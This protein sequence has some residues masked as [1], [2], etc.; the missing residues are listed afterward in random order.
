M[1]RLIKVL[2]ITA[3]I[4]GFST[5]TSAAW[6]HLGHIQLNY[7]ADTGYSSDTYLQNGTGPDIFYGNPAW[8][9]IAHSPVPLANLKDDVN[10]AYLMLA[11][12]GY[13]FDSNGNW[14]SEMGWGGHIA[15]DWVAHNVFPIPDPDAPEIIGAPHLIGELSYSLYLSLT[16]HPFSTG[17][18]D[19]Q[20]NLKPQRFYPEKIRKGYLNYVLLKQ[21]DDKDFFLSNSEKKLRDFAVSSEEVMTNMTQAQITEKIAGEY[22]MFAG[23]E[24]VAINGLKSGLLSTGKADG[25]MAQMIFIAGAE[26]NIKLAKEQIKLWT[27][28]PS[29]RD[30]SGS[31]DEL[32]NEIRPFPGVLPRRLNLFNQQAKAL[33]TSNTWLG[34]I[35]WAEQ[36]NSSTKQSDYASKIFTEAAER[37]I[38]QGAY[39]ISSTTGADENGE[40]YLQIAPTIIDRPQMEEILRDV[41][42]QESTNTDQGEGELRAA[43][44]LRN[45]FVDEQ[46]DLPK[47]LD[48]TRPTIS[49]L[50]PEDQ[51]T[52][53]TTQP[54]ISA[55]IDDDE[56][57]I[58]ID[59]QLIIMRLD[60]ATVT[61]SYDDTESL[62]TYV[63]PE[64]LASGDHT[65]EL[66]VH[67][68]AGNRAEA[69]SAFTVMTQKPSS[70]SYTG[71][72]S[73]DYSD[74]ANL[75]TVLVDD[76]QIPVPNREVRFALGSQDITVTTDILG[77]A[78]ALLVIDQ[79]WGIKNLTISFG[80][81][82]QYLPSTTQCLFEVAK[83]DTLLGYAGET[84]SKRNNSSVLRAQLSETDTPVGDLN[85]KQ[86][87]FTLTDGIST[88]IA[89]TTTDQNGLAQ[90]TTLITVPAGL[91]NISASFS[92]GDYYLDSLSANTPYVVWEPIDG[93]NISGGGWLIKTGEKTNFGF[94]AKYK[95]NEDWLQGQLQVVDRSTDTSIHA[96]GFD[97]LVVT[98]DDVAMLQGMAT[99]NGVSGHSFRMIVQDQGT[100]GKGKDT[101]ELQ[102]D[103]LTLVS[104]VLDGGNI[105]VH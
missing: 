80:G 57:G 7:E 101:F 72:A 93:T 22:A 3:L 35:A 28:V 78:Q 27:K 55:T 81:D 2:L 84:I 66:E 19:T 105:V 38:A 5:Q 77:R 50:V 96:D 67:D 13:H 29:A 48:S 73:V 58:G 1:K 17:I 15:G 21:Y 18:L 20:G 62:V 8:S 100:P 40:Q 97:W 51:S 98:T 53:K 42:I 56:S 54:M 23:S 104:G 44:A 4:I 26:K 32:S 76:N 86:I 30:W 94:T 65:I 90:I 88:Q 99:I 34:G 31:I 37:A 60:G 75:S 6:T 39:A 89:T 71:E 64:P 87:V 63:P 49:A 33:N 59:P 95:K 82:E 11:A 103:G 24:W 69:A 52:T 25:F 70:L 16:R 45:M 83:E 10:F 102:V 14:D 46:F 74:V 47:L 68:K 9:D 92:G 41:I 85:G 43:L 79:P 61:P 91:Y 36:P 12:D